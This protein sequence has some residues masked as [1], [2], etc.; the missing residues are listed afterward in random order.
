MYLFLNHNFFKKQ[1][2]FFYIFS[3]S[4]YIPLPSIGYHHYV[5]FKKSLRL[6]VQ[7]SLPETLTSSSAQYHFS[8]R[9]SEWT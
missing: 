2:L 8:L 5:P 6:L 1:Y 4:L 7:S 9:S 3:L